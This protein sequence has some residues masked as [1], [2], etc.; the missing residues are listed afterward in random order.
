MPLQEGREK[1]EFEGVSLVGSD[2]MKEYKKGLKLLLDFIHKTS[3][4]YILVY[5]RIEKEKY[6]I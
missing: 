1:E 3:T 4:S 5:M 2:T 6:K